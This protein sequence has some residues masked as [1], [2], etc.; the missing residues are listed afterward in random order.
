MTFNQYASLARPAA[1]LSIV[2]ALCCL[3]TASAAATPLNILFYGSSYTMSEYSPRTIP[4]LVGDIA[5]IAGFDVPNTINAALVGAGFDLHLQYNLDVIQTAPP[6]SEQWDF[7]VMQ[8]HSLATTHLTIGTG[9]HAENAVT[10]YQAVALHS[11]A[12]VPVLFE[13][14]ARGADHAYYSGP[15]PA[16]PGGPAEMQQIVRNGYAQSAAAINAAASANLAR[17]A[18]VGDAFEST[19]FDPVLYGWDLD[20]Q[21]DELGTLLA[22]L[23]IFESIYNTSVASLDLESIFELMNV[24]TPDAQPLVIAADLV[25]VP[26]PEPSTFVL[27]AAALAALTVRCRRRRAT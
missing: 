7:V 16:F 1:R 18:A 13:T 20:H 5:D 2:L 8:D 19:G 11:P 17:I 22:A 15:T 21:S 3:H 6:P 12:V 27:A 14:W 23:V 4:Q 25:F 24:S 9:T 26:A 10:L